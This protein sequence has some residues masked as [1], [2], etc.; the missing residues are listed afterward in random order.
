MDFGEYLLSIFKNNKL[1]SKPSVSK[2]AMAYYAPCHQ[3]EQQIGQPYYKLLKSLPGSDIIQIG[4]VMDC[5]G[6]G[7]HLGYKSNFHLQAQKIGRP[8]FQKFLS[9]KDR[10]IVTDCLSCKMQFRQTLPMKIF[11]PLELIL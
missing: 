10:I 2:D 4:G 9:E 1:E 8:L 11:H 3:R 6:M 7:G 5:C